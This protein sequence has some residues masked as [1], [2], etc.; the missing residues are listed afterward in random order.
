MYKLR[1]KILKYKTEITL[2]DRKLKRTKSTDNKLVTKEILG[3]T[4]AGETLHVGQFIGREW[5]LLNSVWS[6]KPEN[7]NKDSSLLLTGPHMVSK[8]RLYV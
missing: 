8:I 4:K 1:L 7:N 3:L 5:S 2:V 6:L